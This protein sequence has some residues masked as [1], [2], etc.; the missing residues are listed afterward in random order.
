M[1][2]DEQ[3]IRLSDSRLQYTGR[4][5]M[6]DPDNPVFLFTASYVRFRM[7]GHHLRVILTN[8]H[9]LWENRLGVVINGEQFGV[10]LKWDAMNEIDLSDHLHDGENDVML[11]KR[12]D[13]CCKITLHALMIGASDTLLN[14]PE[15]QTRRIE[16]YGDSVSAG[17]VSE[18]AEYT[19]KRDP[20][21]HNARYNNVYF[22][23]AWQAARLLDAEISDIAQGGIALQDGNGYFFDTGMLSCWDKLAY[24][25]YFG[26][27][28]P[29]DF[30]RFTPHVVVV[31]IGQ[32]DRAKG[33]FM[34]EDYTG[35]KAQRWRSDYEGFI[36]TIRAKYPQAH[37][38]L[39]TTIMQHT[40][41]WD[42]AIEAVC[43]KL[44]DSCVH[45][46]LY[47]RNGCG[48]PGHVRASEA[49]EM[50]RELAAY[51]ESIPNVWQEENA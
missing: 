42:D 4:V 8:T 41:E 49:T 51:I 7:V 16:F 11:F 31:A 27:L 50:A 25:P 1:Q 46:F 14:P 40:P 15:R 48:T 29:W 34:A 35:V 9:H 32:N 47:T 20:P 44:S 22:S 37:I 38:L 26:A 33:D 23:Y 28:K 2:P 45:H 21:D 24:N 13:S 19:G 5:D 39:T 30:S 18:A 12:Q 43:R 17:E 36:R 3:Y 10:L 6:D